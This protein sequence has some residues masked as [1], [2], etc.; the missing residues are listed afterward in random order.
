MTARWLALLASAT[1][2]GADVPRAGCVAQHGRIFE[3]L[4]VSGLFAR[5]PQLGSASAH[6]CSDRLAV[7]VDDS[8]L[9][10]NGR[11]TGWSGP[12][13]I[14]FGASEAIVAGESEML[15]SD[16]VAWRPEPARWRRPV[17]VTVT[18]SGEPAAIEQRGDQV[19]IATP[20][21]HELLGG[22]VS[23]AVL[24]PDKAAVLVREAGVV[25]R[26]PRGEEVHTGVK[27][28][29]EAGLAWISSNRVQM[30]DRCL[31]RIGDGFRVWVLPAGQEDRQ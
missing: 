27:L 18:L 5:G 20:D 13:V 10:V 4:G 26:S 31:E 16:G 23:A 14:G 25:F 1:L 12:A 24:W 9:S 6:G 15:R 17:A 3:L 21:G 8:G 28:S 7:F 29:P 2:L 30:G 11:R 22:K 19:W